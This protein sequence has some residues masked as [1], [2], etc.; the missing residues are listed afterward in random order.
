MNK[1]VSAPSASHFLVS[2]LWLNNFSIAVC[3]FVQ[4]KADKSSSA[5]AQDG[6]CLGRGLWF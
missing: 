5:T 1:G 2:V 4:D 6:S 3:A